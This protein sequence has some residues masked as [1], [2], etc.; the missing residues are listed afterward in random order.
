LRSPC[1]TGMSKDKS[2]GL[3]TAPVRDSPDNL[4]NSMDVVR[5]EGPEIQFQ[6]RTISV[7]MLHGS[8]WAVLGPCGA[9]VIL[10]TTK[11]TG[12]QL[13]FKTG[14]CSS[15]L[16]A[17]DTP[18]GEERTP[19]RQQDSYGTLAEAVRFCQFSTRCGPVLAPYP[20][21]VDM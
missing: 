12:Y 6:N 4:R 5:F 2:Q 15:A 11:S 14:T 13:K 7:R 21:Y 3:R 9:R 16:K 1:S 10:S 18:Y 8:Y 20:E 17:P 19:M